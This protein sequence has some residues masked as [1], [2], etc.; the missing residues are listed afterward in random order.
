MAGAPG[1]VSGRCCAG[2]SIEESSPLGTDTRVDPIGN[3]L[4]DLAHHHPLPRWRARH[5]YAAWKPTGR[6]ATALAAIVAVLGIQGRGQKPDG[7]PGSTSGCVELAA[8]CKAIRT[9]LR[10][11]SGARTCSPPHRRGTTTPGRSPSGRPVDGS[12]GPAEPARERRQGAH[13]VGALYV[14]HGLSQ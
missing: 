8:G 2:P 3:L 14:R 12:W 9:A 6:R 13:D 5:L 10:F 11:E 7:D 4:R 1:P